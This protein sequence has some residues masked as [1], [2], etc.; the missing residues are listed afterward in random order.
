MQ[1]EAQQRHEHKLGCLGRGMLRGQTTPS[2]DSLA[3]SVATQEPGRVPVKV[4]RRPDTAYE[5]WS[6]SADAAP[7]ASA[8]S[9][10]SHSVS[11]DDCIITSLDAGLD[12]LQEVDGVTR[13]FEAV[14][15]AGKV[16]CTAQSSNRFLD[17]VPAGPDPPK[18]AGGKVKP[19]PRPRQACKSP[20]MAV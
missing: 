7:K 14:L 19:S 10:I 13:K 3:A 4:A 15:Q 12:T 2:T 1:E 16:S 18:R 11:D 5:G 9:S 6:G 8:S 20:K 17:R